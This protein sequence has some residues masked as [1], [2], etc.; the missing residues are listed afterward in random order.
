[1]YSDLFK[2]IQKYLHKNDTEFHTIPSLYERTIKIVIRSLLSDITELE[3]SEGFRK[4]KGSGVMTVHQFC[5]ST[6]KF[7]LHMVTLEASSFI[8]QIYSKNSLFFLAV[9]IKPFKSNNASQCFSCQRF[10]HS[11]LHCGYISSY[12]KCALGCLA[13]YCPKPREEPPKCALKF[14]A[15]WLLA[16]PLS[17]YTKSTLTNPFSF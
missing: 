8:K 13:K 12:I 1:V 6:H 2:T 9:K 5:K 15:T 10:G 17:S 11:S 16:A 7:P 14:P 3:V 4:S